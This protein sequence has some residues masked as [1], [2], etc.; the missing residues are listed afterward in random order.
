MMDILK[1]IVVPD[2]RDGS[3]SAK[4]EKKSEGR[5]RCHRAAAAEWRLPVS[6]RSSCEWCFISLKE[7]EAG[8]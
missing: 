4:G 2:E 7:K 3:E 6:R 8:R 5:R 1:S